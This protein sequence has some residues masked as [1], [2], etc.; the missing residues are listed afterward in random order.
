VADWATLASRAERSNAPRNIGFEAQ[1]RE[2]KGGAG[3][4]TRQAR[5]G[6]I[7]NLFANLRSA[8][9]KVVCV[10]AALSLM[11]IPL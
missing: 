8:V 3:T 1:P 10:L 11:E 4:C 9:G 5:D 7:E 6:K 2:R